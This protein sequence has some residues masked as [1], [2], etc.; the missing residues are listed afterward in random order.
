MD[1]CYVLESIVCNS[2]KEAWIFVFEKV[3]ICC[4]VMFPT[5]MGVMFN[6]VLE[7]IFS[8]HSGHFHKS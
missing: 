7:S 4:N 3:S 5:R 1:N 2:K 8:P 6:I